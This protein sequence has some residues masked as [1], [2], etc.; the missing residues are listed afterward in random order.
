MQPTLNLDHFLTDDDCDIGDEYASVVDAALDM[1]RKFS[2]VLK[3]VRQLKT[4]LQA[5][6][7]ELEH[8]RQRLELRT[9]AETSR[10]KLRQQSRRMRQCKDDNRSL[11]LQNRELANHLEGAR[12]ELEK[13]D[14]LRCT[15]CT[16]ALKDAML[17]CGHTSC[18]EC[19]HLWLGQG[20]GKGCP[21]CKRSFEAGDIRDIYLGYPSETPD[22]L[23]EDGDV[24]DVISLASDSE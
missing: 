9:I 10:N 23:E 19:L 21:W 17:P 20:Q 13:V 5:R 8:E 11:R 3:Q 12:K 7:A 16:V 22:A 14:H 1:R 18:R 4:T 2:S 15:L 24:T 6:Q